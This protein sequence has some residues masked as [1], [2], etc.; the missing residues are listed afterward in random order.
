MSVAQVRESLRL[1]A[2]LETQLRGF[3]RR[4]WTIKMAEAAAAAV[5]VVMLA[6]LSVFAL[7]RLGDTPSWL[8][9]GVWTAAMC[10]CAIVPLQLHRWIWRQRRLEQLARLLTVKLPRLGDQLL[11]IIELVH[12]KGEQARSRALCEAAVRCVARDAEKCNLAVAAPNSRHRAWGAFAVVLATA[13][14][15][16]GV[17]FP[18]AAAN[19]WARFLSP[20]GA[21]PRYTF[22]VVE[23]LPA[24]IIVPHGEPFEVSLQLAT[25]SRW[26]PPQ[27]LAQL[28]A[29]APVTTPL[30]DG[31]YRFAF[32]G[33]IDQC[34]LHVSI[35]DARQ[36]V[37]IRPM[38]RPELTAIVADVTLPAYLG[39]TRPE[40][41]DVRGGAIAL[42]KG[43]RVRFTAT[44]NRNLSLAA[45][46][47]RPQ[48]PAGAVIESPSISVEN[49]TKIEFRWRDEFNL[50]GK[51]P[52]TLSV[53]PCDDE[54]P[55]LA[56]EDLPR[57]KVVLDT[58]QLN[59]RVKAEDDFGVK[60]VGIEWQGD[61][62][63]AI[64]TPAKGQRIIAAG[65]FEKRSV[66]A[67]GTFSA[68]SLGIEPQPVHLRVYTEDYFP[69]RKRVYS[70]ESVLYVLNAEQHAIWMTEQLNKWH[71][72][73]LEV[74]D[75]ELQLHE[76]NKQLRD[77][78]P[79]E[80]DR[81]DVRRRIE[82]QSA[83][84]RANGRRLTALTTAGED[85]L[86]QAARNPQFDV[87]SLDRWAEML[88][89]LKGI[90]ANRMPSVADLLKQAAEARIAG[91]KA[92]ATGPKA[93]KAAGAGGKPSSGDPAG[94]KTENPQVP[95]VVDS[96]PSL[97]PP[98][99]NNGPPEPGK[100]PSTPS[101]RLPTTTLI[102][103][104]DGKKPQTP[105]G[106]KMDE[107][108]RKQQDL[109]VEFEKI[110]N[111][112]NNILANLEGSTLVKR[113]KA[114]SREQYRVAGRV[115][116][117]LESS[118]GRNPGQIGAKPEP[119]PPWTAP[120]RSFAVPAGYAAAGAP[121]LSRPTRSIGNK[122]GE[123]GAAQKAVYE[124]LSKAENTA[125][126]KVSTIM[127]DLQ[128]YFE[129]RKFLKFKTVLDEMKSQD[130]VGGLRQ[131]GDDLPG[132]PGLSIAVCEYWWDTMDRWAEDLVD[133]ACSGTCQCSGSPD[134]LPPAVVLEVLKILE[135]EVNLREE[136]R[137]AEQARPALAPA[138]P[139]SPRN[140]HERVAD[141]YGKR[142][143]GLSKTQAG[144]EKR[145][146]EVTGQIREL[147]HADAQFGKEIRL[148][149]AVAEVMDEAKQILARP[150]TGT[151][152]IG[153][154]TEA[155]EL[156]LQS[157]RINP[158]GGGGGGSTPGGGGAGN[159]SDSA[160]ALLG[161][162]INAKEVR[163]AGTATQAVGTSGR[164]L[165][166]EFRAGLDQYFSRLENREAP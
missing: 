74:R 124:E 47:G 151:P 23:P 164:A 158:H 119:P 22:A 138:R 160:L 92:A 165:P 83:A 90:A 81:P 64:A 9:F 34:L 88:Q 33:Q 153:A 73:A 61:D 79:K 39:R 5:F 114:A 85:L 137:V 117:L 142:A 132:E 46:D 58:E 40:V 95:Q 127:D 111:E 156:L 125:S 62:P 30:E 2:G 155:I 11:G 38:L 27:A 148:L 15:V 163:D 20:W 4:V 76:T 118:F 108:V 60:Q 16:L 113:L 53:S 19:A 150:N 72:Q 18:A 13:A 35:G 130:V 166:E 80:L 42:V 8:R 66:E 50:E 82:N 25:D 94:K 100:K 55:S 134:S 131:I 3:R 143:S 157:R 56:C 140:N 59:F 129:R 71:R 97:E 87:G 102:G 48:T 115:G 75:R 106:N 103:Q 29:Q 109:L 149:G 123:L 91:G 1:P 51:E 86:R 45:V 69:G 43:S 26:Y 70:P 136:T 10:G 54:A 116:D 63:T 31:R 146:R 6:F 49:S 37:R 135:A 126:Q 67:S 14:V 144:L 162:G 121:Q 44:A 98:G 21:T 41:K 89:I 93:G 68:Q 145:V 161:L 120:D 28:G 65:G 36:I 78:P 139:D 110:V 107:A 122:A 99:K 154:E 133:P 12:S 152:A 128:A 159:T 141:E 52:F 32:P 96:E 77:L 57:A 24:E 104:A 7:D 101:L 112:L 84:E 105:A 147:P 17:I